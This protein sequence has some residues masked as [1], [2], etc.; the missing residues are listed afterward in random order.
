VVK[1]SALSTTYEWARLEPIPESAKDISVESVGSM[2]SRE[3]RISFSAPVAD[4]NSWLQ[5]SSGTN[6]ANPKLRDDGSRVYDVKPGG[7][8]QFAKVIVS[9]DGTKV[10]I[11]TYWS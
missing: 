10:R 11:R 3:F 9:K 8:A 6:E 4:V 5:A 7:G 2:F 1:S